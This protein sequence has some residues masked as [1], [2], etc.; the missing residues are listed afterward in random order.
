MNR[1]TAC[2]FV[3]TGFLVLAAPARAI[4]PA[5]LNRLELPPCTPQTSAPGTAISGQCTQNGNSVIRS[6]GEAA[7][8]PGP[9][10]ALSG[11]QVSF[12]AIAR[13]GRTESRWLDS[14]VWLGGAVPAQVVFEAVLDGRFGAEIVR[15]VIS[16]PGVEQVRATAALELRADPGGT[17]V[18]NTASAEFQR[19]A[20]GSWQAPVLQPLSLSVAWSPGAPGASLLFEQRLSTSTTAQNDWFRQGA[21]SALGVADFRA[22]SGLVAVRWLDASGAELGDSV[23]WAWVHGTSPVPEPGSG[24]LWAAGVAAVLGLARRRRA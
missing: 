17:P 8:A 11:A 6:W 20:P 19:N 21:G 3:A 16:P 4:D 10:G 18:A 2:A 5:S 13:V 23:T 24:A 12:E 7:N 14:L 15:G 1:F 22:G 9:L